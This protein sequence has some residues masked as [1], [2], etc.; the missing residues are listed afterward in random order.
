MAKKVF[1]VPLDHLSVY[2]LV[3]EREYGSQHEK[4]M[5][6]I[7]IQMEHELNKDKYQEGDIL[8]VWFNGQFNPFMVIQDGQIYIQGHGMP[9]QT[10]IE[11][12]RG[13]G[14]ITAQQVVDKLITSGLPKT[15]FGKIKCYNCHSAEEG[16]KREPAFAQVIANLMYAKGYK[17]CKFFGYIGRIDSHVKDGSKGIHKYVRG[18]D[19][20]IELGPRVSEARIQFTPNLQARFQGFFK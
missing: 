15:F 7:A 8:E 10:S 16:A 20:R 1:F 19:G 9:G 2:R 6:K 12:G 14:Y 3:A 13:G 18:G 5:R 11:M 17:K 4:S